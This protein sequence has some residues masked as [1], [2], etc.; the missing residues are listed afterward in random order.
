M[1]HRLIKEYAFYKKDSS[2]MLLLMMINLKYALVLPIIE[3][4]EN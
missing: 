3:M 4:M 2:N 1:T